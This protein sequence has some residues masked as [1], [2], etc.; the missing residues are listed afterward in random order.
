MKKTFLLIIF[1]VAIKSKSYAQ[2]KV[3]WISIKEALSLQKKEPKKIL[4]FFYANWCMPSKLMLKRTF[5]DANIINKLNTNY[6]PVKFNIESK[7]AVN[8]RGN[9]HPGLKTKRGKHSFFKAITAGKGEATPAIAILTKEAVIGFKNGFVNTESLLKLLQSKETDQDKTD[10]YVYSYKEDSKITSDLKWF[11]KSQFK[12][13]KTNISTK[14]QIKGKVNYSGVVSKYK[15]TTK[16]EGLRKLIALKC[17]GFPCSVSIN[18]FSKPEK[19]G[20]NHI[21]PIFTKNIKITEDKPFLYI[22]PK[23]DAQYYSFKNIKG[24]VYVATGTEILSNLTDKE[25]GNIVFYKEKIKQ[26]FGDNFF[27]YY[28]DLLT[29]FSSKKYKRVVGL[30]TLINNSKKAKTIQVIVRDD[31]AKVIFNRKLNF[32]GNSIDKIKSIITNNSKKL[33]TYEFLGNTKDV[34]L[35]LGHKPFV[36]K[37]ITYT[38]PNFNWS[39]KQRDEANSIFTDNIGNSIRKEKKEKDSGKWKY[40]KVTNICNSTFTKRIH[41]DFLYLKSQNLNLK[42]GESETIIIKSNIPF[43][44]LKLPKCLKVSYK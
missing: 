20:F 16:Q 36:E 4:V 3:N 22:L 13:I 29:N 10:V 15:T 27:H 1:L 40:F 23:N 17:D 12:E 39:K 30:V 37:T 26:G 7:E 33:V 32:S 18:G 19:I 31:N 9:L 24:N 2:E 43:N 38:K 44:T 41:S 5:T 6:Y 35:V 25:F 8:Y 14:E 21:K 42:P 34:W 28:N 11:L